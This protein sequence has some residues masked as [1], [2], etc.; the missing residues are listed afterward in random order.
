MGVPGPRQLSAELRYWANLSYIPENRKL[1]H[2]EE[3][4]DLWLF[5]ATAL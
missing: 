1:L 3:K 4:Y 2:D 5:E